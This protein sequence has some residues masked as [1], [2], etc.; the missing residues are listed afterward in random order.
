MNIICFYIFDNSDMGT[1][2]MTSRQ[3]APFQALMN[4]IKVNYFAKSEIYRALIA[5]LCDYDSTCSES[6]R[7]V[8]L[9][10]YRLKHCFKT[11]SGRILF[12]HER[13]TSMKK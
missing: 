6:F 3:V 1:T 9:L 8:C 12:S 13:N 5:L 10:L 2:R 4:M 7:K 11:H